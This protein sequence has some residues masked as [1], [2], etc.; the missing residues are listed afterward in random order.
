M[1]V[2]STIHLVHMQAFG[3]DNSDGSPRN[4]HA[5]AESSNLPVDSVQTRDPNVQLME[6]PS[7]LNK[8][9]DDSLNEMD[10]SNA[11]P[12]GESYQSMGGI[13]SSTDPIPSL[14]LSGLDSS[15]E[16]PNGKVASSNLNGKRST[17]W[18]RSNVSPPIDALYATNHLN[19]KINQV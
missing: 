17:F 15:A 13:L 8:G 1:H 19:G 7:K 10:A 11:S 12:I 4:P 16:K 3:G 2:Y 9:N 14:H 18:G 5:P 6:Q